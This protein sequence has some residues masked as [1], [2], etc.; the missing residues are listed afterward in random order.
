MK[1]QV[2]ML[3]PSMVL[4]L[5]VLGCDGNESS[6][7]ASVS[8][9]R[10]GQRLL[11]DMNKL[12]AEGRSNRSFRYNLD[13]DCNL[14]AQR[15]LSGRPTR[16]FIVPVGSTQLARFEYSPGLG[17]ALRAPV[18]RSSSMRSIFEAGSRERLERMEALL[19][20]LAEFCRRGG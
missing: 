16:R 2:R 19:Q 17:Y 3:W 5:I 10:E 7:A 6:P 18:G 12:A 13:A 15:L 11:E 4:C 1:K 8:L 9:P 20:T 14:T